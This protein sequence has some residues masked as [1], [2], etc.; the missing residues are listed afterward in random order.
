MQTSEAHCDDDSS[1]HAPP[2]AKTDE[3]KAERQW[4][5]SKRQGHALPRMACVQYV[6]AVHYTRRYAL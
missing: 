1:L 6:K 5:Q 4:Y 2:S 3:A